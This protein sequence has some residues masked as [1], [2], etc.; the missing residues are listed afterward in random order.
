[1]Q[2]NNT[3]YLMDEPTSGLHPADMDW[4]MAVLDQLVQRGHTVI[5]AEHD[6]RV[7]VEADW[8]IDLGPGA[9]VDGGQIVAS[10]TPETVASSPDS[11]TAPYLKKRLKKRTGDPL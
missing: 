6:M 3:L 5:M 2:R 7:A 9:G 11:K 4:L 10:G 8:I 1:M